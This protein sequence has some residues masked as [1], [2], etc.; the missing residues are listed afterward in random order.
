MDPFL[1]S[2]TLVGVVAQRLVRQVCDS[3]R[4]ELTLTPE[5]MAVLDIQMPP[6]KEATLKVAGGEGC[7]R[8]RGTGLYGR[9]AIFEILAMSDSLRQ[10]V[11]E[12][13]DAATILRTAR[14]EGTETLREAAVRKLAQGETS[15][16]EVI[17][18]TIDED[19]R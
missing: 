14:S 1:V 3:C 18:V 16:D 15:Y 19:V 5:Q 12:N 4:A 9:T 7:T 13:A 10:H 11:N 17:R 8:C 2:S 6:G